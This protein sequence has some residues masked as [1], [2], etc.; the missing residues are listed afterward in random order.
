MSERLALDAREGDVRGVG[1]P[2]RAGAVE[3]RA[4]NRRPAP[5]R[6]GRAGQQVGAALRA[7]PRRPAPPRLRRDRRSPARFRSLARR[8]RSW[9]PPTRSGSNRPRPLAHPERGG[10]ERAV[11]L[12][13]AEASGSRPRAPS[14]STG[15][16]PTAWTASQ[17]TGMPRSRQAAATS[18]TGCSVPSSLLASIRQT[19]RV[20][21][22]RAAEHR[23]G[24]DHAVLA[25][26]APG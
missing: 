26:A 24:G 11:E 20:S 13:A 12:V 19:S 16:L 4:R 10:A 22:R 9:P 15:I 3:D 17:S 21:G 6:S 25:R 18:A 8:R 23:R 7:A 14:T 5:P 2:R 1:Q